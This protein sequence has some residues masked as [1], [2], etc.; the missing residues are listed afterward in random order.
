MTTVPE[1][2]SVPEVVAVGD[3]DH[4]GVVVTKYSRAEPIKP[5]TVVKRSFKTFNIENFLT[6]ILN[7]NIDGKVTACNDIDEAAKVFE[8]NFRTILDK[9][10]PIKMFQM[11]KH[12]SPF[13][14][15]RTK[16]LIVERNALKE[17][18]AATGDKDAEKC[19][20]RRGKK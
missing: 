11:R 7:S 12:Y 14:S 17:E 1:K 4:L 18:A 16:A 20:K 15:G 8:E 9:H 2:L 19:L 13:V 10:A 6:D 3:S 5:K